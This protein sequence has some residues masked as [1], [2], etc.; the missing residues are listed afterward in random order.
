VAFD[1]DDPR[2]DIVIGDLQHLKNFFTS[3]PWWRL[4]PHDKLVTANYG[5]CVAD[6]GRTY[7]VYAEE[8]NAV[9]LDLG[10]A[11]AS[12]YS[13]TLYDPRTGSST[14]LPDY[15][16]SGPL[17]LAPPDTQDWIFVVTLGGTHTGSSSLT[18]SPSPPRI[19]RRELDG[20]VR[21]GAHR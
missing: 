4:D 10:G 15:T 11:S 16:G 5:Y 6:I 20:G 18:K 7:V 14:S 21:T 8:S 17:T 3:L 19:Q 2:N 12:T 9:S 13:V 1:P